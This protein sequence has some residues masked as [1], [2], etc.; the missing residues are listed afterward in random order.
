MSLVSVLSKV[1]IGAIAAKGVGSMMGGNSGSGLAGALSSMMG[2][3]SGGNPLG[4]LAGMLGGGQQQSGGLASMLG[5]G[6]QGGALGALSGLLGGGSQQGGGMLA[7]LLGGAEKSGGL[8]GL[9]DSLGG[10]QGGGLGAMLNQALQGQE[11]E[12]SQTEEEQAA[13]LLKAM[14][15]AAKSDGQIDESEQQKIAE[16]LGDVSR[17]ELAVVEAAMAAPVDPE[18]LAASVPS[19]MEQQ[20]YLMSLLGIDLDSKS[21]AQYLDQLARAMNIAPEQ[22]NAI[23]EKVGTPKLYG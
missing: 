20:V 10:G 8:G 5:G 17:E 9:L 2:G 1:A 15:M 4:A 19:G 14:I 12:P 7:G 21:E 3:G 11:P 13:L 6:Q 22:A 18:G 23:H 16:H